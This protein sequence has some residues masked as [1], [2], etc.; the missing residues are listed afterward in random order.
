MSESLLRQIQILK[1]IPRSPRWTTATKIKEGLENRGFDVTIRTIQ[2][3]L[4]Q[5]SGKYPLL[6]E[7]DEEDG[8]SYRWSW[9]VGAEILNIPAMDHQT[10][11]TFCMMEQYLSQMLPHQTLQ[12]L[13]PHFRNA[14]QVLEEL[15]KSKLRTWPHKIRVITPGI[16]MLSP[17][18]DSHVIENVYQSLYEEKKLRVEYL[19]RGENAPKT[20]ELNPLGIVFLG[21]L[22]YLVCT[23]WNYDDIAQLPLSRIKSAIL[24]EQ[25]CKKPKGFNLDTH[26]ETEKFNMLYNEEDLVIKLKVDRYTSEHFLETP[27]SKN[28][29]VTKM[30]ENTFVV[31]ATVKDTGRLRWWIQGYGPYVEVLEPVSLRT[32]LKETA[33]KVLELYKY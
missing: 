24:L 4:D 14:K 1:M 27:L 9:D 33:E 6:T 8:I 31:T 26:I 15:S 16:P 19:N 11:L 5:L 7:V 22:V 32:E 2:R 10:A 29:E 18:I 28:Q 23:M 13:E 30:D 3:N 21:K 17:K 12:L 20:Q 25:S